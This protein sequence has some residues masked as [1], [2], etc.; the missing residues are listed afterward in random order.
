MNDV[1]VQITLAKFV[2][3]HPSV[4]NMDVVDIYNAWQKEYK[5]SITDPVFMYDILNILEGMK[6]MDRALLKE[7]IEYD[8]KEILPRVN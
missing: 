7:S 5:D 3:N 2:Y 4:K 1:M 8:E 6:S